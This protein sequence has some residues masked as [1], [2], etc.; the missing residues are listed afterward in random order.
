MRT[1]DVSKDKLDY[2]FDYN[3]EETNELN[4]I[5]NFN[6]NISIHD[7]RRIALWKLNRILNVS[8]SLI[9][10]IN[11]LV[12][13]KDIS[14]DDFEVKSII[15]RLVD[16]NG[17]GYPLA[18]TI[19]KFLRPD[20]FPIIDVRAYR[21]LFGKKLYYSSYSF[22]VYKKYVKRIYEIRD[23][24]GIELYE[25]DQQLYCFDKEVNGKI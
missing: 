19:L 15:E 14:I 9:E 13:K 22:N 1:F 3:K 6:N 16:C 11:D 4:Q 10:E 12:D 24:L 17:I 20:V 5:L 21:A 8:E 25:V 2:E 23:D 7:L 18:S